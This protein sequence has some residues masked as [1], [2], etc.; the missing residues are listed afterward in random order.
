MV[1]LHL[2]DLFWGAANQERQGDGK[3]KVEKIRNYQHYDHII[4]KS[5]KSGGC[6]K[7]MQGKRPCLREANQTLSGQTDLEPDVQHFRLI[8]YGED[9]RNVVEKYWHPKSYRKH[10]WRSV[11]LEYYIISE[12]WI[13][14]KAPTL[15]PAANV[16]QKH[17]ITI[18][19]LRFQV[20][21]IQIIQALHIVLHLAVG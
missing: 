3:E 16:Q 12:I 11:L 17:R 9:W 20:V 19:P 2:L 14:F 8:H 7:Q 6:S 15:G 5:D 10:I 21:Q 13:S 1:K 4:N 18:A